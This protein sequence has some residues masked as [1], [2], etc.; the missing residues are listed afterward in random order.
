MNRRELLRRGG[1]LG[2]AALSGLAGCFG[3]SGDDR[4]IPEVSFTST[5]EAHDDAGV[6]T[7]THDSGD[8]VQATK[9]LV[10]G[11]GFAHVGTADQT[12]RGIWQGESSEMGLVT[13]GHS[14][15]VG[16]RP[17]YDMSVVYMTDR[18]GIPVESMDGPGG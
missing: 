1:I 12:E 18:V 2:T 13:E 4:S 14:V 11:S 5:Y 16:A 17:D 9:L 8:D 15:T 7:V 3:A 6:L 10:R